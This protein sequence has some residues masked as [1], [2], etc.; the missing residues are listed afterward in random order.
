MTQPAQTFNLTSEEFHLNINLVITFSEKES[1]SS[2]LQHTYQEQRILQRIG[3]SSNSKGEEISGKM[4]PICALQH[5]SPT[6]TIIYRS[7]WESASQDHPCP[8]K[9]FRP[10]CLNSP[11]NNEGMNELISDSGYQ[12]VNG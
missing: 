12:N 2:D 9:C 4:G 8:S 3:T 6:N 11:T 5:E 7:D 10:Y 1:L